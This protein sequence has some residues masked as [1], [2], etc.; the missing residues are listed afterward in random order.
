MWRNE[1]IHASVKPYTIL[2]SCTTIEDY[3][4]T[5]STTAHYIEKQK[6]KTN[7]KKA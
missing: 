3:F 2:L 4:F 7:Q 6:L 1:V 5:V